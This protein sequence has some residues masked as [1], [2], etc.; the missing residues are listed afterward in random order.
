MGVRTR[1]CILMAAVAVVG[2]SAVSAEPERIV[3]VV[4]GLTSLG[5][6]D[7]A[8]Y[9]FSRARIVALTLD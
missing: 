8:Q 6:Q 9:A 4:Y 1:I 5:S 3:S 2:Q 7:D